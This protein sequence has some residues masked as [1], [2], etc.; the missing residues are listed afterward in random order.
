[1]SGRTRSFTE[2]EI[3][4]QIPLIS[5]NLILGEVYWLSSKRSPRN[6]SPAPVRALRAQEAARRA[7]GWIGGA[8]LVWSNPLRVGD[9]PDGGEIVWVEWPE[10]AM[11]PTG[12]SLQ[13]FSYVS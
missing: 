5:P 3:D 13:Y 1:M 6:F 11:Q 7:V 2:D 8:V 4:K 10:V 9:T 12:R